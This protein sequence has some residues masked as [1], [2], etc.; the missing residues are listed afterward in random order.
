MLSEVCCGTDILLIIC[1]GK[2]EKATRGVEIPPLAGRNHRPLARFLR[3]FD[4]PD[5]VPVD[6]VQTYS[7]RCSMQ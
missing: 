5:L 1:E 4:V 6:G 7:G 2:K 3:V